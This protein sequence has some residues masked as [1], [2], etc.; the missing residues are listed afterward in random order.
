MSISQEPRFSGVKLTCDKC[1]EIID[2]Y[3]PYYHVKVG[4][5]VMILVYCSICY[6]DY[7]QEQL[8]TESTEGKGDGDRGSAESPE[9]TS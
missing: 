7:E 8:A 3:S 9:Q 1:G 5:N 4:G 2:K 6:M